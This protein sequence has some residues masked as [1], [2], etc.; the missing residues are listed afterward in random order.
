MTD[1]PPLYAALADR[2]AAQIRSGVF[3]PGERM[4]SIRTL[5]R[6]SALSISTV[7]HAL[8]ELERRGM[9]EARPRSG[10]FVRAASTRAA[11]AIT[12][13][14]VRPRTVPHRLLADTFVTDSADPNLIPLG[15]A[16]LSETLLPL[17]QLTRIAKDVARRATRAFASYGPPA[18]APELRRALA[19]RLSSLGLEVPAEGVVVSA[20][21]M[22]AIGLALSAVTKPGD[23]VALESPTFFGFLQL[24]RAMGLQAIELP[25][26]P[27]SGLDLEAT[28]RCFAE[29]PVRAMVVTPTFQNPTGACMPDDAKRRLGALAKRHRVVLVEDD[30]YGDLYFGRRRPPPLAALAPSADVIYCASVSKNLAPGLRVG[31]LVPGRHLE[32]ALRAKLSNAITS[33]GLNQLVVADVLEAGAFDRH[34]RRLRA[35][36]TTQVA[37]VGQRVDLAFPPHVKVTR[38]GGG[39]LLWLDLGPG[40]D[41]LELYAR[42]AERGVSL[43][44]G[45]LCALDGKYKR[46]IRLSCGHPTSEALL[47]GVD[48]LGS[49]VG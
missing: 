22:N 47:R 36:L 16:V 19:R 5:H 12:S 8:A 29:H 13:H 42:A 37:A 20:G 40:V 39:F 38:P 15:G 25:V 35:A 33:P 45:P 28:A 7:N 31:W 1:A 24:V 18:G 4:P 9:V 14:R 3:R 43:L 34:L 10:Y 2:L 17:K 44:P 46:C 6:E 11:P 21:C 32:A 26:D 23:L 27:Q 48:T 41:A 30:V 49:L